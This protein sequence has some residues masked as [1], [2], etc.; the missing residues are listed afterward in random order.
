M[1]TLNDH[2]DETATL[3]EGDDDPGPIDWDKMRLSTRSNDPP[4]M[5]LT[6]FE[7]RSL[8]SI[9]G[10]GVCADEKITLKEI[11]AVKLENALKM[12]NE[13]EH[14]VKCGLK[15]A[16]KCWDFKG[17]K[18]ASNCNQILRLAEKFK[19][20]KLDFEIEFQKGVFQAYSKQTNPDIMAR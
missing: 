2:Y 6:P 17:G 1:A 16:A 3:K 19:N 7:E 14:P 12:F 10:V 20:P 11:D 13:C 4:S 15:V 9:Q 8:T 5:E 18:N